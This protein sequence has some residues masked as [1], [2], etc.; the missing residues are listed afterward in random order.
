MG[1]GKT[2]PPKKTYTYLNLLYYFVVVHLSKGKKFVGGGGVGLV[3]GAGFNK[4]YL[5]GV[6]VYCG[7]RGG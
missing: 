3:I 4:S 7:C 5:Y 6:Y 1:K 2:L